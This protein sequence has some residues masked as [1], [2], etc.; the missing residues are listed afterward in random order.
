MS[1]NKVKKIGLAHAINLHQKVIKQHVFY[2]RFL[3]DISNL[4]R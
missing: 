1:R 4:P 3:M 2:V